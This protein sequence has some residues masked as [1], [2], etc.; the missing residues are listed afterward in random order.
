MA[1]SSSITWTVGHQLLPQTSDTIG[2]QASGDISGAFLQE[3]VL[4]PGFDPIDIP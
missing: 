2:H 4:D 3:D 1:L